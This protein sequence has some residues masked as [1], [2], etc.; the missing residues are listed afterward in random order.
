MNRL[1]RW[2][3]GNAEYVRIYYG[4]PAY[5]GDRV[6]VDG[7]PGRIVGF[8]AGLRVRFDD[9]PRHVEPC[10]PTWRVVY[11]DG[12][13]RDLVPKVT[14]LEG[15]NGP[16]LLV[17]G[18]A[19]VELRH[20]AVTYAAEEDLVVIE[21][22]AD[23][24]PGWV[25]AVPWCPGACGCGRS[26]VHYV[27]ARPKSRGAFEAAFIEARYAEEEEIAQH[28]QVADGAR[29]QVQ[30]RIDPAHSAAAARCTFGAWWRVT[31]TCAHGC[32][33]GPVLVCQLHRAAAASGD[34]E[35]MCEPCARAG[36]PTVPVTLTG[37]E[38]LAGAVE[39]RRASMSRHPAVYGGLR[40]VTA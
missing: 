6:V 37:V 22:V 31:L 7:R 2:K 11:V 30:V 24:E 21:G 39:E 29:C 27:P 20:A 8:D 1:D 26:S 12:D 5:R 14:L 16:L 4:V 35:P 19:P 15:G 13:R 9:Q 25:R 34:T 38:P 33:R 36:R 40:L 32:D 17:R 18:H 3:G 10:H 28:S 23:I